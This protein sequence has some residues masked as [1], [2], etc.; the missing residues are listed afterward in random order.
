M[1]D[2]T[3][4]LLN[5]NDLQN[6]AKAGFGKNGMRSRHSCAR[7]R[8]PGNA[9]TQALSALR[10]KAPGAALAAVENFIFE[11]EKMARPDVDGTV[12]SA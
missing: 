12:R 9:R 7:L 4:K 10:T 3:R 8:M 2:V 5:H 11:A 6:D 1:H